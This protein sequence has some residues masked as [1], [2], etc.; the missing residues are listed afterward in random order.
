MSSL[1]ISLFLFILT[2]LNGLLSFLKVCTISFLDILELSWFKRSSDCLSTLINLKSFP[3]RVTNWG[4]LGDFSLV[5]F[6]A[7]NNIMLL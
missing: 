4:I 6:S 1:T 7:I 2:L 3:F 5:S